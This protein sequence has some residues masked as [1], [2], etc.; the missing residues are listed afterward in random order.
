LKKNS[1]R[2]KLSSRSKGK[3]KQVC[4]IYRGVPASPGVAIGK[5]FLLNRETVEV[6]EEKVD[7][8]E[9]QKEILKFKKALDE[10]KRELFKTKEKVAKRIDSDHAKI[11]EGQILILEDN[12]INDRVIER[13]KQT[14]NNAEFVYKKVIDQTIQAL[15]SSTDEYLKERILD[16]N[17]VSSRLIYNLLGIKHLTLESIDSP[18]ILIARTLSPA[19]VVHMKKES[20]L[21]FATDVGG[22]TSHVALLA[23]SMEIPAVVGLKNL[24]DQI[25]NDQSIILDGTKGE[26]VICPDE[27]T[28]KEFEKRRKYIVKK[29]A[30][31][32][33]LRLLLAETQDKRKIELSANIEL[34]QDTDSALEYGAQG[35][36][37]FRTE[38]L[39]LAQSDLPTEE[40]QYHAYQGVASKVFPRSVIL[41]TFDLGGDK[42]GQNLGSLYEAN[43]FLGWRA[44]R[45]CLDLPEIFKIQLRAMLKASAKKNIKIMFPMISE[46]EELKSAKAILEE[47][48]DELREK[49]IPFDEN[50]EVGIMV[51]IP[52]AALAG[53]S[54]AKESNFF[55]IGTNDLIQYT[56]AVDRGNER[57]A[58]LY[59]GFHPAVLKLIKETI[60]AGHRNGIWVG[61]CGEMAGDPLAT[62]LL[63]GMGVDELSTSAMAI[64]EIKKIVRSVTFEEAQ[65]VAQQVLT[66]STISDI[67][68]FLIEDYAKRFGKG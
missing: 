32:S 7:E 52:S 12:L 54:L 63:V 31:L 66:L 43:P 64:P 36:G 15:S 28:L 49:R 42:F 8:N 45:A 30:E 68:K 62:V 26:V 20:I 58:H 1:G 61:L 4:A 14:R 23:K 50:M 22:V 6:K 24:F 55:S 37:L 10:T 41:R 34:P 47:V 21:G 53:D 65:K 11:F 33:E 35:I 9:I 46:V 16:I 18:V 13:I 40:E 29:T 59:Q 48:K 2:N 38:Y 60:D 5:A 3:N 17:A 51:E 25:L 67:K 57:I 19:D 39:Y 56:L 44:I 27:E